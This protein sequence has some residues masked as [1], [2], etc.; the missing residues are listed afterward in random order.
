M[1]KIS[2]LPPDSALDGAEIVPLTG[3]GA[4]ASTTVSAIASYAVASDATLAALAAANW[5]ANTIPVG[6]GADTVSQLAI[7]A[8]TFP[9]RSSAGN[10]AAKPLTDFALTLLDD[11]DA[12]TA[13]TT[14]GAGT[15]TSVAV[16]G[17]TGLAVSGS[18]VTTSGTVTL[19][20]DTGLQSLASFNTSAFVVQSSTNVFVGRTIT[21]TANRLSV[22]NGSGASADPV[23]NIDP[24]YVGQATITTL[25]T[26]TT[27]TWNGTT[28]AA[29]NGGTGIASYT[30]GNYINAASST[31]LQQRT[32]AQVRTDLGVDT[33]SSGTYTPT[34]TN[35]T[36][37]AA[38][39][40]FLARW[41]RVGNIV[42]VSGSVDIDPTAAGTTV[43]EMSLPV[44]SN[45]SSTID[46][47]GTTA[48]ALNAARAGTVS[49]HVANDRAVLSFT[50]DATVTNLTNSYIYSYTVI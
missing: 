45:F 41:S 48:C 1:P 35:A 28:I 37:I 18:P 32:P 22:T 26:V 31:T 27:G 11:A 4:T 40:A 34:L 21:G 12:A 9:A 49:A 36:N 30:T 29:A 43:L 3:G 2:E 17:S 25:G 19:T 46:A 6:S 13:R 50:A 42:T 44:A 16:S 8:S 33:S 5:A 23:L 14:L 24:A 47:G 20:L 38:S 10:V 15:V 39:T 7:T